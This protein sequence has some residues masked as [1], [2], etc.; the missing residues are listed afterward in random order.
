MAGQKPMRGPGSRGPRGPKPKVKNP[1]KLFMRLLRY[2][3]K[4]YAFHLVIVVICIFLS[5]LANIQ[6]TKF[7]QTLIDDYI[8]PLTRQAN[9]DFSE[10]ARAIGRVACF[11]AVGIIAAYVQARLMVTVTQGTQRRMRGELFTHMENLP[12]KYFDTHAHGD[13]MS[14]YTNDIDALRQLVSQALPQVINSA[15]TIV[16]VFTMMLLLNVPLTILTVAMVGLNI[17]VSGKVGAQSSKYF[18]AQ[19]KSLG[20]LNGYIEEMMEGQKVVKVFTH[21]E[22]S[23]EKFNELNENLFKSAN[24]AN[25]FGNILG[26]I[27]SN[28]GHLSYVVAAAV[29]GA[30]ALGN[31]GGFT[32][33]KL[34]SFLT[35]NK[36]FSMPINQLSQQLN[37]VIMA[38]A[39]CERI[40]ALL[41]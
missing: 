37:S 1:G 3:G 30:L 12:I 23:I 4:Y 17:F 38:L 41:D 15:I 13:I 6:G 21:E 11:Y 7:M 31:I 5:V 33:G 28:L 39:G 34:A 32:I 19:Q 36:S 10:L 16:G 9:P 26:P 24:N 8:I 27:N 35:Y 40:F 18:L 29:G 20:A 14:I 2:I 22:E 25:K